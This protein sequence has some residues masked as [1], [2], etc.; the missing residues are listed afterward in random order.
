MWTLM[1]SWCTPTTLFV[2]LNLMIGTIAVTSRFSGQRNDQAPQ[3]AELRLCW[4]ELNRS[5]SRLTE[6]GAQAEIHEDDQS[7][8]TQ[9][10]QLAR[11]PSLLERMWSNKLPS[12]DPTHFPPN[13]HVEPRSKHES[14]SGHETE[15][16][17]KPAPARRSQKMKKSVS[18][19]VASGRVEDVDAVELRRPQTVRETKSK[20]SETMSF[21][22]DEEVD[23]KA[24]DFINR[25]KQQLKLQRLDS[26]LR[27]SRSS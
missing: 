16:E 1:T 2:V 23:A 15:S 21:G 24:D 8:E 3:L 9:Q 6:V 19:K 14:G 20:L 13:Q 10:P 17:K 18:Q 5:T 27:Y 22:D 4:R 12:T 11:T 7:V 26:L 25:F